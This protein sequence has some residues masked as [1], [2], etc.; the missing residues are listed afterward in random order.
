MA[1]PFDRPFTDAEDRAIGARVFKSKPERSTTGEV[2]DALR[3]LADQ[4]EDAVN[5]SSVSLE[6][7]HMPAR[8]VV[9]I[10]ADKLREIAALPVA[11]PAC[12]AVAPMGGDAVAWQYKY[13][14]L[15]ETYNTFRHPILDMGIEESQIDWWVFGLAATPAPSSGEAE[16]LRADAEC[17]WTFESDPHMEAWRSA[18]GEL[19]SFTDGGLAENNV[20]F[21]HG[22]GHKIAA[23]IDTP[24]EDGQKKEVDTKEMMP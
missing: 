10:A 11:K 1:G 19:W 23:R 21:C 14:H 17:V 12:P 6:Q 20:R 24:A 15:P 22:C 7:V 13:K 8:E 3:Q 16:R 9:C 5:H 4:I 18:C 2:S